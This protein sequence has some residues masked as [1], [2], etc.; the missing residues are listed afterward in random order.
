MT[1][2]NKSFLNSCNKETLNKATSNE[3]IFCIDNYLTIRQVA[4]VLNVRSNTV[5]YNIKNGKIKV[6]KIL[7]K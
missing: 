5:L 4:S 3:N 2:T 6:F 1:I 7:G